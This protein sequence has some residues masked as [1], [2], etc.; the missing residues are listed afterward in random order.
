MLHDGV[1]VPAAG[2]GVIAVQARTGSPAAEAAPRADHAATH[3]AL[4]AERHV[5][6]ALEATCH[7]PVGVLATRGVVRGFVGLPDGSEYLVDEAPT[8]AGLASRLLAAGAADLLREANWPDDRVSRRRGAGRSGAAD[9]AGARAD[10]RRRRDPL[11]PA[12]PAGHA[13]RRRGAELVYV[14]KQGGGPQMPQEEIDRLLVQYGTGGRTVVRLKGGD[15]FVFGRGGEEALVLRAAGIPYEVVPGRDRRDRRARLRG[16]ARHPPRAGVRRR[17]RDRAREPGQARD[18]AG[19]ARAGGVPGHARLLHGREGAAA[20]RVAAGGRRALAGRAR[21]R[22]RA[23][24]AARA[25]RPCSRRS[26][27]SARCRASARRRSRSS[28][29]SRRCASSSRGSRRARCTGARWP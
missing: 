8:A 22:G 13:R 5:V 1:F 27:R 19:L 21:R 14:G 29:R 18:R 9:R 28:G 11:R 17:V 7:T 12:D 25:R 6:R 24:H 16:R 20:D 10:R 4:D 2:Q 23:R 26:A 3:A 15:P